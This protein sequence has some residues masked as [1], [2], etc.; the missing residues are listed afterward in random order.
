MA[1]D[2]GIVPDNSL[3][4]HPLVAVIVAV[5]QLSA[6]LILFILL[7][8]LLVFPLASAL[9]GEQGREIAI[10]ALVIASGYS[11]LVTRTLHLDTSKVVLVVLVLSVLFGIATVLG[12]WFVI[13]HGRG[14]SAIEWT[15]GLMLPSG[16][17]AGFVV[18]FVGILPNGQGS[19]WSRL[20]PSDLLVKLVLIPY[21]L[22]MLFLGRGSPIT[23]HGWRWALVAIVGL[24]LG[25][26]VHSLAVVGCWIGGAMRTWLNAAG[27]IWRSL[28][29]LGPPLGLFLMGYLFIAVLFATF[30]AAIWQ[31]DNSAY[32]PHDVHGSI[33]QFLYFSFI[34]LATVGYG[35]IYPVSDLAR[36]C[37]VIE[38]LLG[39]LWIVLVLG[40]VLSRLGG[41]RSAERS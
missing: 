34:T 40:I 37:T 1:E 9:L 24:L 14:Q 26:L 12:E 28:R 25:Y 17:I 18:G 39:Q 27:W 29:A 23:I 16:L 30:H 2:K 33:R 19:L 22:L 3:L 15:A 6:F 11:L 36:F 21:F 10:V 31:A 7:Y 13:A 20:A 8:C 41:M 4:H 5:A 38:I 32:F 35:D